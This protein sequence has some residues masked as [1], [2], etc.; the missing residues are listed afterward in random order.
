MVLRKIA[1]VTLVLSVA[2]AALVAALSSSVASQTSAITALASSSCSD[3]TFVDTAA[4]PTTA[5]ANNDLVDDCQN[6]VAIQNNWAAVAANNNL[7]AN[8]PLRTWGTGTTQKIDTW[9]GVTVASSRVT[10]LNLHNY[11]SDTLSSLSIVSDNPENLYSGPGISGTLPTEIGNLAALTQLT[12]S[13]NLLSG[14]I[15]TQLGSLTGLTW[16][17]LDN[18]LFSGSIPTQLG[19]LTALTDLSLSGN[20]LTGSIPVELGSLTNL[21]WLILH[22]NLL[23]GSIPAQ[24][25][26][27]TNLTN[28]RLNKNL[29]SGSIPA[30]LGSLAPSQSGKLSLFA[31]CENHLSGALPT[32]L[33]TG[34]TLQGYPTG[35]TYDPIGCQNTGTQSNTA[36]TALASSSCSDGTFVDTTANPTTAGANNDLVDDCQNL[37]AIQNNWAAIAANNNLQ[38]DHPLRTWGTGTAEKID[39][40]A[41]I[42]VTSSRVA[43]INL[44]NIASDYQ[45]FAGPGISG[46]IPAQLGNLTAL[47]S[48]SMSWNRF[49]GSIPTQ[50]SSLT[51]LASL[52]FI[53]NRLTGSIPA[54]LGSLTSLTN[55][56]L[57]YNRLTGAIPTQLGSLTSLTDLRLRNNRLTGGIPT[58]LGSLTS[59]TTLW[60]NRNLLSGPIPSALGNLAPSQSG[61]LTSFAFCQNDLTGAVPAA[62]R[63]GVTLVDYPVNRGYDPMACQRSSPAA[64]PSTAP[65]VIFA[66]FTFPPSSVDTPGTEPSAPPPSSS[67]STTTTEPPTSTTAE[68]QQARSS[69]WNTFTVQQG[70]TTAQ[71]IR[72]TLSLASDEAI[73]TW[74]S[75]TQE[76]ERVARAS[77]TL[78]AGTVLTFSSETA[79]FQDDLEALNLGG[80]T[81]ETRLMQ[82]WNILNLPQNLSRTAG[83]D[84]L[85]ADQL[86]DCDTD[87]G[88]AAVASY[89]PET[90]A[91]SLWMPC[92]PQAEASLTAG[93]DPS[94]QPLADIST[95][96]TLYIYFRADRPVSVIWNSESS[97]YQLVADG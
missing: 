10:S 26:S 70:S 47:T 50:I 31:F 43:S 81:R 25:S 53:S 71:Q 1:A 8:H 92:H 82:G 32:A 36:I 65:P 58:Q 75:E 3:G 78:P 67:S 39:T 33:R 51:S 97:Q 59:L 91:W 52:N 85:F 87:T 77:Q 79:I 7:Q 46:S 17:L 54:Q 4:N 93:D 66:P 34:V 72:Q 83:S 2:A 96:D 68:R 64:P 15:P 60:L 74:S 80:G 37:V 89:S 11:Q 14:S 49:S 12:L 44:N 88:V 5:G 30:Q 22:N 73:Y 24:L 19:S 90:E 95:G 42:T 63:S 35:G 38:T 20:R 55:I 16:L 69:G 76:W 61:S 62:L 18:N 41:G 84:F 27:L 29:L 9:A 28:F 94:Y 48:I 57:S 23:S 40:W 13:N 21:D 56:S 6:L 86:I 45:S